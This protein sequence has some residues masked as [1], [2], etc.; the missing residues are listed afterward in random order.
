VTARKRGGFPVRNEIRNP[1]LVSGPVKYK[2]KAIDC[3]EQQVG[4]TSGRILLT[5][6]AVYRRRFVEKWLISF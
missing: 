5:M 1:E 3:Q 2:K 6:M 4:A